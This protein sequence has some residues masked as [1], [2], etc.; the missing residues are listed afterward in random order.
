MAMAANNA[1]PSAEA[2]NVFDPFVAL[3]QT[4]DD[5]ASNEEFDPFL[6]AETAEPKKEKRVSSAA[7]V[8]SKGSTL[9]PRLVVKF[10]VH[11]EVSS[12]ANPESENEGSSEVFVLGTVLVS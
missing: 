6:I 1:Q 2:E 3:E 7:S 8:S 4:K 12:T 9:P 5:P 10:K 11:E